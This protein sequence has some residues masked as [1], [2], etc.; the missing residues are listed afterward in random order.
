MATIILVLAPIVFLGWLRLRAEDRLSEIS[1]PT[2]AVV[3][4]VQEVIVDDLE[5]VN[6]VLSWSSAPELIAPA[7]QGTVTTLSVSPGDVLVTGDSIIGVNGVN[8]IAAATENPF[9]RPLSR[10][11]RGPDVEQLEELLLSLGHYG[12]TADGRYD[13]ALAISVD[14]LAKTLGVLQPDSTFDPSW[15]IW[16]PSDPFPVATVEAGVGRPAPSSGTVFLTGHSTIA[17][18][19]FFDS[20]GESLPLDGDWLVNIAGRDYTAIDGALTQQSLHELARRI[21]SE[22]TELSGRVRRAQPVR[23]IAIPT[24]AVASNRDGTECVWV[25]VGSE[26]AARS[27]TIDGGQVGSV[28]V[29]DGLSS[30]DSVLLNPFEYL[31][32][33]ICP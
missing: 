30:S 8:R 31:A 21:S 5:A 26:F 22:V 17:Q 1:P 19:S 2:V 4:E 10:D 24:T 7:W 18:I 14:A 20:D 13:A 9:W 11:N 28:F 33:P 6:L 15:I 29:A 23:A 25:P 27:V 12:G 32:N 3:A 16:L